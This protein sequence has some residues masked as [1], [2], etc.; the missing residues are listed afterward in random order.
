MIERLVT[1]A[2]PKT[3]HA[4]RRVVT[5]LGNAKASHRLVHDLAPKYANRHGGYTRIIKLG[6]RT[7]DAAETAIIEFV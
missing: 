6:R 2:R 1:T 7:G 5:A 4:Q 3:V